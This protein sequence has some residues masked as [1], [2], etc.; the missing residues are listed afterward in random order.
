MRGTRGRSTRFRPDVD[1]PAWHGGYVPYDIVKEG[2]I[3]IAVVL[4]LTAILAVVFGSPDDPAITL[5]TWSKA[6]PLDFAQTALRELSGTSTSARYGA[7]Y[8]HYPGAPGQSLGPLRL[9]HWIGVR[10]PVNSANDFVIGPLAA[11]P[12]EPLLH[13]DLV[14]W[15]SASPATR[16][17][18]TSHYSRAEATMAIVNG[19]VVVRAHD[20]GPVPVMINDLTQMARSGALDQALLTNDSF[21]TMDYTKTLLFL[22]DG[23][24]LGHVARADHL[25]GNQWGMMNETGSYPGQAWMWLYTFW[26]QIPPFNSSHNGDLMVLA[27]MFVLTAALTLVP[28]IPGLRSLP[29]RSRVYRLIWREH[30]R[31]QAEATEATEST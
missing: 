8:N 24:Y 27:I 28:F 13:R 14:A 4:V 11:L 31:E 29:R 17:A 22:A 7:P 1:A 21:Y 15:K 9:E 26:Y 23:H 20:A 19:H 5:K 30:Y 6:A 3:A 2:A 16:A 25:L 12:D 10:I 18:W